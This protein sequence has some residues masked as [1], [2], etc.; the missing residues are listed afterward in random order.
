M[1]GRKVPGVD[2]TCSI[3][4]SLVEKASERTSCSEDLFDSSERSRSSVEHVGSRIIPALRHQ[5]KARNGY[6]VTLPVSKWE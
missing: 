4:R 5:R 1:K 2:T 6:S 3:E